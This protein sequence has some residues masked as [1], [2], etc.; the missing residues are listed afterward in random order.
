M[1]AHFGHLGTIKLLIQK[2]ADANAADKKGYTA[3]HSAASA[4]FQ[5]VVAYLI[6]KGSDPKAQAG[7]NGVTPL[8]IAAQKGHLMVKDVLLEKGVD[9]NIPD[10]NNLPPLIYAVDKDQQSFV[11]Q[12]YQAGADFSRA[13]VKGNTALHH[14]C[15]RGNADMAEGLI[16][17]GSPVEAKN[18]DGKTPADLV[19]GHIEITSK[20]G[21]LDAAKNYR[22]LLELL[23]QAAKGPLPPRTPAEPADGTDGKSLLDPNKLTMKELRQAIDPVAKADKKVKKELDLCTEKANLVDLYRKVVMKE[24]AQKPKDSA[25]G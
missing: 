8:H 24:A 9:V 6:D 5:H 15:H 18:E 17:A 3:V 16:R 23:E 4:G 22:T 12:L 10:R 1:A 25:K 7:D 13:D 11:E 19:K 14:A 2:G 21:Y 20:E